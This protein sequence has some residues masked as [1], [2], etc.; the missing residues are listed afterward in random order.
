MQNLSKSLVLIPSLHPDRLLSEYVLELI[1][2]G[3][4]RILV[5]DDGSGEDRK[6]RDIFDEIAEHEQCT[7]LSYPKNHGKGYAL[8]YGF[9]YIKNNIQAAE[10]I[11]TADSDGQHTA[12]DVF[13]MLQRLEG[14]EK[15][16]ILGSRSFSDK[17]IPL[18]SR[19]GNKTTSIFFKLLYG[20]Y[21]PDTQT[22]L[23]AFSRNQL[24]FLIGIPGNRFEYEMN[25]LIFCAVNKVPFEIV[26]IETIYIE[27]NKSSHFRPLQDSM[28]IYR[29]LFKG[30][31]R[32][33]LSSVSSFLIDL[34]LFTL[35]NLV[36]LRPFNLSGHVHLYV[37][38]LIARLCSASFNFFVNKSF[39]FNLSKSKGAMLKYIILCIFSYLVS[40]NLVILLTNEISASNTIMKAIIDSLLYFFNYRIQQSWVFNNKKRSK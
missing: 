32:Y 17:K 2:K 4:Q 20:K 5:I 24:E 3:V 29:I 7:V 10:Y 12:E 37:A 19:F 38:A 25:M 22:G 11:V 33:T 40:T 35:F 36:L 27:E 14:H 23:R 30:F 1:K 6:Y 8:K 15:S 9:E 16:M 18:R 28:R 26:E 21:L 34:G 13:K 39:V 31:F